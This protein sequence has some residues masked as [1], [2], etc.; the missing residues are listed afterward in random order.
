MEN[1]FLMWF[2]AI[3]FLLYNVRKEGVLLPETINC[4]ALDGVINPYTEEVLISQG[5]EFI[6]F[7]VKGDSKVFVEKAG[8]T[9]AIGLRCIKILGL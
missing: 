6:V 3:V 5:G 7:Y 4:I 2:E 9:I 8:K 1:N